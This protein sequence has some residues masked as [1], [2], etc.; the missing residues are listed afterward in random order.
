MASLLAS[1]LQ[2]DIETGCLRVVC[3]QPPAY[4][5]EPPVVKSVE[6]RRDLKCTER[7]RH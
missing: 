3:V 4:S 7:R 2:M 1:W 5:K 6:V